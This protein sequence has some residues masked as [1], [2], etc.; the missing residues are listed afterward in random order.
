MPFTGERFCLVFY[1]AVG[2]DK[3]APEDRQKLLDAGMP[4][5]EPGLQ[6]AVYSAPS[7]RLREA[8]KALPP[9]LSDCVG[10]TAAEEP[11]DEDQA[12]MPATLA[13]HQQQLATLPPTV[14]DLSLIH[15]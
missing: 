5:P 13:T 14:K 12:Q 4:L 15:N 9:D 8:A 2:Y 3:A 1:T 6:R 10:K 7:Q 11:D